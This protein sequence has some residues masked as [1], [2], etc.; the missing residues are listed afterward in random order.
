[1][2]LPLMKTNSRCNVRIEEFVAQSL[3]RNAGYEHDAPTVIN[4]G[5]P[6][7][8]VQSMTSW[9]GTLNI[10]TVAYVPRSISPGKGQLRN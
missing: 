3:G 8:A 10:Q 5:R 4:A 2:Q 6:L 9:V 1:M 7:L